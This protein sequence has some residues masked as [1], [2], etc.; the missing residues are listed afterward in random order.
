MK[1]RLLALLV[2]VSIIFCGILPSGASAEVMSEAER[3]SAQI[4]TTY[5]KTLYHTGRSSL[6]GL[7]GLMTC[8]QLY[9]LGINAYPE[10]YDGNNIYDAYLLQDVTTGGYKVKTYSAKSYGL[11]EALNIITNGGT[12]NAYNLVV[13]FQ[14]TNTQAGARFGHAV[15]VHAILDGQVY[16]VEGFYTSLAGNAGNVIVC[17]I[18]EFVKFF[19]DWTSFE[20][21]VEFGTS[22]YADFCKAY[23]VNRVISAQQGAKLFSQPAPDGQVTSQV[24]RSVLPGERLQAVG[25][26]ENDH[27]IYYCVDN[28]DGY[29]FLPAEQA[30]IGAAEQGNVVL[31]NFDCPTQLENNEKLLLSGTVTVRGGYVTEQKLTIVSDDGTEV[32]AI[33]KP[34]TGV[35]TR[36]NAFTR[37]VSKLT[38]EP[39]AYRLKL[40]VTY[41]DYIAENGACVQKS[42]TVTAW[43]GAFAVGEH[44]APTVSYQSTAPDGWVKENGVW[45]FYQDGAPRVGWYCY[46]GVDYY[47]QP[48]G[49]VTTGW[50]QINGKYRLFTDTGAMRIGWVQFEDASYYMLSNGEVAVGTHTLD[51]VSYRF[52]DDGKLIVNEKP[53]EQ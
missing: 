3:I 46:E 31:S 44:I 18:D 14:W 15:L 21:I 47:F 43:Q 51:G 45:C 4:K 29:A 12:K 22:A 25:L 53:I 10:T 1:K 49:A 42:H 35:Q 23:P 33:T 41:S 38:F 11:E 39:G 36:L 9:V 7:C 34:D 26:Y 16:F 8:T 52:A 50:A 19:N 6:N 5:R 32:A 30:A 48:D 20:G 28:G 17:S 37:E 40:E 2:A 13:G 27:G 24:L